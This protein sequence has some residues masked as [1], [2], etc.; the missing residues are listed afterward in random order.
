M[1]RQY[2]CLNPTQLIHNVFLF[3]ILIENRIK[4]NYTQAIYNH[5]MIF[6]ILDIYFKVL[7]DWL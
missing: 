1:K 2:T 4:P 7:L 5:L 3:I 6:F